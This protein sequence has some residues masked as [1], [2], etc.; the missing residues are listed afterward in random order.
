MPT[1]T[2]KHIKGVYLNMG[3]IITEKLTNRRQ[4][5]L[6]ALLFAFTYMTSYLTRINFGGIVAEMESATGFARAQLSM[7]P[8]GLFITYGVG[9][10]ISGIIGDKISPKKLITL[11]LSVSVLMNL[12]IPFCKTPYEMLA[13]W[14]VNGFA[15]AFMW[16][17]LVRLM[18]TLFDSDDYK[19]SI[20]KTSYGSS[21]GTIIVYLASPLLIS[22]FGWRSVFFSAAAAGIITLIIWNLFCYET[23]VAQKETVKDEVG[24]ASDTKGLLKLLF[25]PLIIGIV[26]CVALQGMLR[27][28]IQTWMPTYIDDT[29][30]LGSGISILTGVVIPIFSVICFRITT[31]VYKKHIKNALILAAILFSLGAIS[32]VLLYAFANNNAVLS[33]LFTAILTGAMHG[34]NLMLVCMI[35]GAFAKFGKVSTIS[36]VINAFTYVGSASSTWGIAYLSANI[37]WSNTILIW[38]GVAVLGA[39]ICF[40]AS[41]LWK[42]KFSD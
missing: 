16:P 42:K 17:P 41:A 11:G 6:T 7:A 3:K 35:P 27:D 22:A 4:I 26:I 19:S 13:V 8:T 14:C 9:Q 12:L 23:P 25:S 18:T 34:V 39:F 32:A 28:G 24:E 37:G 36:G 2:S 30:H 20:E 29:Y 38:L 33:I 40:F 31:Y 5:N 1:T 10:I 15:Q 21:L